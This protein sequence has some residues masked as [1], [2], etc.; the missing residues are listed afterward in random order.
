MVAHFRPWIWALTLSCRCAFPTVSSTR[1]HMQDTHDRDID[2][3]LAKKSQFV[4]CA[5]QAAN[6]P[7]RKV[8]VDSCQAKDA[9][10]KRVRHRPGRYRARAPAGGRSRMGESTASWCKVCIAG[11]SMTHAAS[12]TY[13]GD[14]FVQREYLGALCAPLLERLRHLESAFNLIYTSRYTARTRV[15]K[16]V[17]FE[18]VCTWDMGHGF[19]PR[20][21]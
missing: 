1:R 12:R 10:Q 17:K 15:R 5:W 6:V 11:G 21:M 3:H 20:G 9:P 4:V 19:D 2:T 13:D 7:L 18:R 16:R 8:R 14:A